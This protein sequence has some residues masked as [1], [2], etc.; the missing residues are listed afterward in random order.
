MGEVLG[1]VINKDADAPRGPDALHRVRV[2]RRWFDERLTIEL[3]LPRNLGCAACE[4]GGCDRC[5]RS[6]AVSVRGR[7]EPP[8]LVTV[9]LTTVDGGGPVVV[10]I[11]EQG[12]LAPAGTTLPR[13]HLYLRIEPSDAAHP[14]S[15]VGLSR[16]AEAPIEKVPSAPPLAVPQRFPTA[17]VVVALLALAISLL[18]WLRFTGR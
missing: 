4:G 1:R 15:S 8:E 14:S 18:A 5:D 13:G 11:P 7:S 10:R 6:G 3:E 9:T 16:K 2:P 12:G 17:W